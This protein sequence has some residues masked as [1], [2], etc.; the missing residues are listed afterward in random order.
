MATLKKYQE[1]LGH[2]LDT[3]DPMTQTLHQLKS[4]IF[5]APLYEKNTVLSEISLLEFNDTVKTLFDPNR[6]GYVCRTRSLA[7]KEEISRIL[8]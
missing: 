3:L 5:G 4:M 2:Y 7:K 8:T 6:L 1:R